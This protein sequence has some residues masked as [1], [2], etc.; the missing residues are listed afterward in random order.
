VAASALVLRRDPCGGP[1]SAREDS[2]SERRRQPSGSGAAEHRAEAREERR[3]EAAAQE[4]GQ[5]HEAAA[6]Q[7]AENRARVRAERR[8]ER[9]RAGL[10]RYRLGPGSISASR[11][12]PATAPDSTR[13]LDNEVQA[14]ER[15][16]DEHGPTERR[17]LAQ[18]VSS[19]Y[20][21]PGVFGAALRE[22]IEGGQVAR[23]EVHF[24]ADRPGTADA[25]RRRAGAVSPDG[26]ELTSWPRPAAFWATATASGPRALS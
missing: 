13:T 8:R 4:A 14:I 15:A 22:A 7:G 1:S 11:G 19:R 24:H 18:M 17:A 16:L 25:A 10:H 12:W 5:R 20:W 23:G 9:E 26:R 6:R 21:G 3:E 2:A